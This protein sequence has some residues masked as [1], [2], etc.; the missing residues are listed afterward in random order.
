MKRKD[1]KDY[2]YNEEWIKEVISYTKASFNKTLQE[3]KNIQY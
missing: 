1:L 3:K 2:K